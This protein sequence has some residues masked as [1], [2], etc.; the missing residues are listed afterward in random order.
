VP[1]PIRLQGHIPT[2]LLLIESAHQDVDL[3]VQ[4]PVGMLHRFLLAVFALTLVDIRDRHMFLA[5]NG[6]LPQS[7]AII[8][9]N[10][11]QTTSFPE[12]IKNQEVDL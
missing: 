10:Y 12:A 5:T 2:A 4:R 6:G 11:F 1:D 8:H 7:E 3:P 9:S